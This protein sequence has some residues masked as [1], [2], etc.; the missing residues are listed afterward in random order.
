M[1]DDLIGCKTISEEERTEV[2]FM[3]TDLNDQDSITLDDLRKVLSECPQRAKQYAFVLM[4]GNANVKNRIQ[5]FVWEIKREINESSKIKRSVLTRVISHKDDSMKHIDILFSADRGVDP[6]SKLLKILDDKC[7]LFMDELKKISNL[8]KEFSS[9]VDVAW[10]VHQ[11]AE[12]KY[13]EFSRG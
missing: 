11:M 1:A 10:N 7:K 6:M 9:H 12:D 2:M 4:K 13:I 8:C 5:Q 3:I